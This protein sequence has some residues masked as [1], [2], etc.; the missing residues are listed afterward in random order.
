MQLSI[1]KRLKDS[2]WLLTSEIRIRELLKTLLTN[3]SLN[4]LQ[5]N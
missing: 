5:K 2:I 1:G 4:N 3:T